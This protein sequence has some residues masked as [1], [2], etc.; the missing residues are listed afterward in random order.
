MF[1][2]PSLAIDSDLPFDSFSVKAAGELS[3]TDQTSIGADVS[4]GKLLLQIQEFFSS[5][6]K[7][8][9]AKS[10]RVFLRNHDLTTVKA[11]RLMQIAGNA[12]ES[13]GEDADIVAGRLTRQAFYLACEA[14]AEAR[15]IIKEMAMEEGPVLRKG[16][17]RQKIDEWEA[18]TSDILPASIKKRLNDG[19]LPVAKVAPVVRELQQ[20]PEQLAIHFT[21]ELSEPEFVAEELKQ[22]HKDAKNVN[23]IVEKLPNIPAIPEEL[24]EGII[25]ESLG[26]S[27]Y[28]DFTAKVVSL[29]EK[30]QTYATRLYSAH[31]ALSNAVDKLYCETGA[32]HPHLRQMIAGLDTLA[33]R[34]VKI[35]GEQ[36]SF[37]YVLTDANM[38]ATAS[39]KSIESELINENLRLKQR[40]EELERQLQNTSLAVKEED[41]IVIDEEQEEIINEP[42]EQ[43]T[44]MPVEPTVQSL[45]SN[46]IQVKEEESPVINTSFNHQYSWQADDYEI[47]DET[48]HF[49]SVPDD[50]YEEEEALTMSY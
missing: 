23:K 27:I 30:V 4:K 7:E 5:T 33:G 42:A 2:S 44:E 15:A 18:T 13:F 11:T 9:W 22:V 16:D 36:L 29:A 43:I 40:I 41:E 19:S 38:S 14:P 21:E 26:D 20:M 34:T 1:L 3:K 12:E 6:F 32:S 8:G 35:E 46:V 45:E 24:N 37:S 17:I 47:E 25:N 49:L 31:R 28:I 39:D 48:N 10:Y 50:E